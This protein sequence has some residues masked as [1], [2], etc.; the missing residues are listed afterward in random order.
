MIESGRDPGIGG[1][2]D[3]AGLLPAFAR[4]VGSG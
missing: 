1:S 4:F 2:G 3:G